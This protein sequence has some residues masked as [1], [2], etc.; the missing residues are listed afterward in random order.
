MFTI[1]FSYWGDGSS[2]PPT[3]ENFIVSGIFPKGIS[4]I[5]KDGVVDATFNA[6]GT[7]FVNGG[8]EGRLIGVRKQSD[9][10][11]VCFRSTTSSFN[12]PYNSNGTD[13]TII[14]SLFRLNADGTFDTSFSSNPYFFS[15]WLGSNWGL[16]ANNQ[17]LIV[18]GDNT[19]V[20]VSHNG[21]SAIAVRRFSSDGATELNSATFN[22]AIYNI[23]KDSNGKI[24][25]TGT[26]TTVNGVLY[27]RM[28]RLNADLS[29]DATFNV[30]TGANGSI[31]YSNVQA[32]NKPILGGV[33]TTIGAPR[34]YMARMYDNGFDG[35]YPFDQS[36]V[37]T[38]GSPAFFGNNTKG[39]MLTDGKLMLSRNTGT[40]STSYNGTTILGYSIFKINTDST[41]DSSFTRLSFN[42]Q[43]NSFVEISD[44]KFLIAAP[45]SM[46]AESQRGLRRLNADGTRDETF[47]QPFSGEIFNISKI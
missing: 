16:G 12:T 20:F 1:P 19:I 3:G 38:I 2:T 47:V 28:V 35:P 27:S 46:P 31:S 41:L 21:G 11:L 18:L 7:G 24:F 10:K 22:G 17:I 6:I 45:S 32:D 13:Y 14:N 15:G 9:G 5:D 4:K 8:F 44:G 30:S 43:I 33:F 26:F 29:I 40:Q 39:L 23:T 37:P 34:S 25:A 36:Y 42:N